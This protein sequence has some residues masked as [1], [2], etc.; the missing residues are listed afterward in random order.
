VP[1]QPEAN[2]ASVIGTIT[3]EMVRTSTR[4][5]APAPDAHTLDDGLELGRLVCLAREQRDSQRE[6]TT[7]GQQVELSAKSA[8]GAA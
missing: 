8:F 5:P 1:P 4:P 3:T 6:A 7:I 2:A